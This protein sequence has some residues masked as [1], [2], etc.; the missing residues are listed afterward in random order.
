[1]FNK[2]FPDGILFRGFISCM[3]NRCMSVSTNF[4][5]NSPYINCHSEQ[6]DIEQSFSRSLIHNRNC[7]QTKLFAT[8]IYSLVVACKK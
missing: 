7:N 5:I 1:M 4:V 8:K 2:T 3:L 6:S